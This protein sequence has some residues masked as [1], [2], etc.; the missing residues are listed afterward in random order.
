VTF[1]PVPL[2]H[3][4]GRTMLHYIQCPF[5]QHIGAVRH[6]LPPFSPRQCRAVPMSCRIRATGYNEHCALL[7]ASTDSGTGRKVTSLVPR[8]PHVSRLSQV[9]CF[10]GRARSADVRP[11]TI[12]AQRQGQGAPTVTASLTAR[13]GRAGRAVGGKV[14]SLRSTVSRV[15]RFQG[16]NGFKGATVSRVQRFQGSKIFSCPPRTD[17]PAPR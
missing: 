4:L 9:P 15:Q 6:C 1:R 5:L 2:A 13:E 14:R 3:F 7:K 11:V 16:C 10:S 17:A 12:G 8:H